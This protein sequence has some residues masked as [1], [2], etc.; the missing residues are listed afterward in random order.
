MYEYKSQN[1]EK[2][3]RKSFKNYR[4]DRISTDVLK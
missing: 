4:L 2:I 3:T 1:K